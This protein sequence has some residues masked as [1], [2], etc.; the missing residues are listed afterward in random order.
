MREP[1]CARREG[2]AAEHP[3]LQPSAW[4]AKGSQCGELRPNSAQI[5]RY[6]H[7][8]NGRVGWPG[9]LRNSEVKE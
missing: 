1:T 2:V 7:G 4:G 5:F 3:N 9:Y 8:G 6:L